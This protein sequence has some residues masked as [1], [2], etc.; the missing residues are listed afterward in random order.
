MPQEQH[1]RG[2]RVGQLQGA[3]IRIRI[4]KVASDAH[5]VEGYGGF[6]DIVYVPRRGHRH[7]LTLDYLDE[8]LNVNDFGFIR[9]NDDITARY[10]FSHTT[11]AW[12]MFRNVR[13]SILASTRFR[14]VSWLLRTKCFAVA[15]TPCDCTPR[16]AGCTIS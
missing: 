14:L 4:P 7:Q 16:T 13:S 11:S 15:I 3:P 12:P 8:N 2:S 5:G 1:G 9:R 10:S 6:G